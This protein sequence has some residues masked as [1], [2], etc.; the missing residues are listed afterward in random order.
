MS[1]VLVAST[2]HDFKTSFLL[3]SIERGS[4][5]LCVH[6]LSHNPLDPFPIRLNKKPV[7]KLCL[8]DARSDPLQRRRFDW[9]KVAQIGVAPHFVVSLIALFYGLCV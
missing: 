8:E 1:T 5:S 2:K 7:L 9:V 3:L 4:R 6:F